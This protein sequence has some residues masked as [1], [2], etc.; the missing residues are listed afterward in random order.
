MGLITVE[1]S[2]L[3]RLA[4]RIL[5]LEGTLESVLSDLPEGRKKEEACS[6]LTPRNVDAI[7][8]NIICMDIRKYPSVALH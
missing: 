6:L 8:S 7:V 1:D 5:E 3:S 2:L 4:D